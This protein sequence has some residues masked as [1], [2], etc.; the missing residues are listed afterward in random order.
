MTFCLSSSILSLMINQTLS[1]KVFEILR[2]Q[3]VTG[4]LKPN[5]RLLYINVAQELDVSLSPVKEALLYLAQEGLVTIIPRK[6]AFVRQI[7][8]ND[9][10]EYAYIRHALES[11]AVD[12]ICQDDHP[13][14]EFAHLRAINEAIRVAVDQKDIKLC[15]RRDN[16]FHQGIIS[17]C[18]MNMLT[19]VLDKL[20]LRNLLALHGATDHMVN[21][22]DHIADVH[23][24][25]VVGLETKNAEKVK[26]LLQENIVKPILDL[27]DDAHLKNE[28]HLPSKI[29]G[30][31]A[32]D[33]HTV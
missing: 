9:L 26:A 6:G 21:A 7:D 15:I 31:L 18:R 20:P 30:L 12:V 13:A 33:L 17:M 28:D 22:G 14:E 11:L 3:I 25:I 24:S 19:D 32:T 5:D 4:V 29:Q 2:E 23:E 1:R 27:M 16:E 10:I 8:L